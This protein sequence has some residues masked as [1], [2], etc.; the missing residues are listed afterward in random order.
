MFFVNIIETTMIFSFIMSLVIFLNVVV[1]NLSSKF[2]IDFKCLSGHSN[3]HLSI[4]KLIYLLITV[5][6]WPIKYNKNDLKNKS[7]L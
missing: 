5:I 7:A 6:V 2:Q 1:F 4:E 3:V